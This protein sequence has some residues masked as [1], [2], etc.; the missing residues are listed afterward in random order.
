MNEEISYE[1]I[2]IESDP[3]AWAIRITSGEFIETVIMFGAIAFNQVKDHMTF[4]FEV[5]S[6]PNDQAVK[7]NEELQQMAGN[8]LSDIIA[9]GVKDGS[10]QFKDR[11]ENSNNGS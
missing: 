1:M 6:S 8:I 4:N 7:E 10:V 5:V 3:D 2:P 9:E 11:N